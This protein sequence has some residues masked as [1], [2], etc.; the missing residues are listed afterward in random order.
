MSLVPIEWKEN[1]MSFS[2]IKFWHDCFFKCQKCTEKPCFLTE[3][4]RPIPA[5]IH[6]KPWTWTV[7]G[8]FS[9]PRPTLF[10]SFGSINCQPICCS[11][12]SPIELSSQLSRRYSLLADCQQLVVSVPAFRLWQYNKCPLYLPWRVRMWEACR[13]LW[14]WIGIR[15]LLHLSF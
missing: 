4:L 9:Y 10:F 2:C 1:E 13:R 7:R 14:L 12:S 8:L 6:T 15:K 11:P 5:I 3:H